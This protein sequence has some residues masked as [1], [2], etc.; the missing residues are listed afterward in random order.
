MVTSSS[1]GVDALPDDDAMVYAAVSANG[2]VTFSANKLI[3]SASFTTNGYEAT[4]AHSPNDFGDYT[5]LVFCSNTFYA[6]WPDNSGSAGANLDSPTKTNTTYITNVS[7]VMYGSNADQ[8]TISNA[9]STNMTTTLVESN[10]DITFGKVTLTGLAD[11]SVIITLNDTNTLVLGATPSYTVTVSNAGPNAANNTAL[12]ETFLPA[13]TDIFYASSTNGTYQFNTNTLTWSIGTVAA[14]ATASIVVSIIVGNSSAITNQA[15]VTSASLD[16]FPTNNSFSLVAPVAFTADLALTLSASTSSVGLGGLVTYTLDVTNLGPLTAPNVVVSNTLPGN[17]GLSGLTLPEGV[18]C[19]TNQNLLVFQIASLADGQGDSIGLTLTATGYGIG[20]DSAVVFSGISDTNTANNSASA[21][22]DVPAPPP[23]IANVTVAVVSATAAIITWDSAAAS[24]GQVAYGLTTAYSS[25]SWMN[26]AL[27]THHVV[28]LTGLLPNTNYFF[29]VKSVA[30]GVLSTSPG[31]FATISSLIIVTEQADY[32]GPWTT[33]GAA[34]AYQGEYRFTQGVAGDA[35]ASATYTPAIALSG[36]YD[37]S[38]WY[39]TNTSFSASTPMVI[40]GATNQVVATVNQSI[41]GGNW[42]TIATGIY[43]AQGTGGS[44]TIENNEGATNNVVAN[45]AQWTYSLT[46]DAPTNGV[47]PGWW[48]TFYFG[49]NNV[50][51]SADPDHDGYSNYAEYVFGTDPTS[52]TSQLQFSVSPASSTNI[53]VN[54]AP[55]QGGRLYQLQSA[56]SALNPVWLTLTNTPVQN[57][58]GAGVFTVNHGAG[59]AVFYRLSA[60]PLP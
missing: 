55:Y 30:G 13:A 57:A 44:L 33:D 60:T 16:L 49:S 5:S 9:I 52:A 17:F 8:L 21:S 19:L 53:L 22:T 48:S 23:A 11:V 3:T 20:T 54:F 43:F 42:V 59:A 6:L 39:P 7:I 58:T 32:S 12:T 25:V 36:N 45:A 14:N 27:V 40:T 46:Q 38:V 35:T 37:I 34:S 28:L 4:L 15:T 51:S 24:T 10:F 2:G 1:S 29:Q 50:V 18:T 41:N 56:S 47:V 26:P 31:A